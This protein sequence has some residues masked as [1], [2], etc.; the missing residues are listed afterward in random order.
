MGS[1][2][3]W[4]VLASLLFL[5]Y[6][7]ARQGLLQVPDVV[8]YGSLAASLPLLIA[9]FVVT[10]QAWRKLLGRSGMESGL[11]ECLA[12]MGLSILGKYIPGKLWTLLGRAAYIAQARGH[13]LGPA[14]AVS[15]HEQVISLWCGL[16]L[17]AIG[18]LLGGG[19]ELYGSFVV[20]AWLGL[21]ILV[22]SPW[23]HRAAER[24][25]ELVSRRS[26]ALP[27]LNLRTT[28]SVLPWV[29]GYWLLWSLG[30]YLFVRGLATSTVE[31]WAG[32]AFPLACAFGVIAVIAPG[33]LGVRE[34]VLAAYLLLAGLSSTEA[35]TIA[36][37]SRPW[38]LCG[39]LQ[40]F[41]V[42]W[43]ADRLVSGRRPGRSITPA[44]SP[45]R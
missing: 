25:L 6:Y 30:F 29:V 33:G 16:L 35:A 34:G 36:V 15:V 38:F 20:A 28:I 17:G 4:F 41:V 10:S 37:A 32:L 12:S 18:L 45:D 43:I 5:G 39:E 11:T 14:S 40:F 44:A 23:A 24:A 8:S 42:G 3:R 9:G 7:L 2:F 27:E 1:Y 31:W 26:L 22:F 19:F 21:S 13:A